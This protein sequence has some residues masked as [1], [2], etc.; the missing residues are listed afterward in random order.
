MTQLKI[1]S[2]TLGSSGKLNIIDATTG[3][4]LNVILYNG[5]IINGPIVV[6]DRCTL[7]VK[8]GNIRDGHI[9]KLPTGRLLQTYG[10]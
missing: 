8:K 1:Y 9:Y 3:R 6:G 4:I 7:V 5:D 10:V 2:V